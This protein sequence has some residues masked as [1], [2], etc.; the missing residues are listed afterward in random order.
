M[1]CFLIVYIISS[2]KYMFVLKLFGLLI[3]VKR[4]LGEINKK[5]QWSVVDMFES[6]VD[7]GDSSKKIQFITVEDG[8]QYSLEDI[9]TMSNQLATW[10][11]KSAGLSQ[12]TS[13]ALFMLNRP[14]FVCICLGMGKIGCSTALLN[15]NLTG[16][17]LLHCITVALKDSS[18]KILFADDDLK[19]NLKTIHLPP[20]IKV[21]FW[22]ELAEVMK[23]VST[24]R[25]SAVCR[26]SVGPHDTY[27]LIF[28][29][30]TTG[31]PK[32]SRIT[33][34]RYLSGALPYCHLASITRKDRVYT[35]LPLYHSAGGMMGVGTCLKSGATMV[36]R[37][38][39]SASKFAEDCFRYKCTSMQ[40]IGE[41]CR[42]LLKAPANELD[43]KLML[44]SAYGNG[45]RPDVWINFQRRYNVPTIVEF[46]ASTEGNLALFN[47]TGQVGALGFIPRALDFLYPVKIV[48]CNADKSDQPFRAENGFCILSKIGEVGLVVSEINDK[49]AARRFEGY[50]DAEATK[51]KILFDVFK[52]GDKYFNTGDLM[53]RDSNGFYYWSD[54]VGDTFRWKGENV[55]TAEVVQ[56]VATVPGV[57]DVAVFGVEVPGCD[58]RAG[59]AA[60]LLDVG[61][62]VETFDWNKLLE[63]YAK[64]LPSYARPLFIRIMK[65]MTMTGTFKHQN[66]EMTKEGFNPEIVKD[67][68]YVYL[69]RE[70]KFSQLTPQLY[71]DILSSKIQF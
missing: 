20:D 50:S 14:E 61:T 33:Q 6:N 1:L 36:L 48:K 2:K 28:T 31:L 66:A 5:R 49:I 67:E 3:D 69:S 58:G 17:S 23:S 22:N 27:L 13:V 12:K 53:R 55:S 51:K 57:S 39:F 19:E 4:S 56:A 37:K 71:Q 54:R 24:A 16:N 46:Y 64:E 43:S 62:S 34:S 26:S 10:G 9:E 52:K 29:S 30:G 15:T 18:V 44:R 40:Y 45:L 38:K 60:L 42:Y 70:G 35:P 7:K 32:A 65:S 25:P 59:M 11:S 63:V 8:R 47:G 41:L 21:M 68:L